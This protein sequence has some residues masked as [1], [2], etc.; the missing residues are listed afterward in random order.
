MNRRGIQVEGGVVWVRAK[1]ISGWHCAEGASTCRRGIT[2]IQATSVGWLEC[3]A[4]VRSL[5]HKRHT[6]QGPQTTNRHLQMHQ[7]ELRPLPCQLYETHQ[8][9]PNTQ[10]LPLS[11]SKYMRA[12]QGGKGIRLRASCMIQNH[13]S[14]QASYALAH[15]RVAPVPPQP[16]VNVHSTQGVSPVTATDIVGNI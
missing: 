4:T 6:H 12:S 3:W 16:A 8:S 5:T 9:L 7:R 2:R 1:Q 13:P 15:K 11:M 10:L 14:V